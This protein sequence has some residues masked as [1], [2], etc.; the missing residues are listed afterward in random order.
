MRTIRDA[1]KWIFDNKL[2]SVKEFDNGN[3]IKTKICAVC[4]KKGK[5]HLVI[6]G[7]MILVIL[8]NLNMKF[9]NPYLKI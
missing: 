5:V 9:G 6:I 2:S 4:R 3:N 1:A 8:I 7:I